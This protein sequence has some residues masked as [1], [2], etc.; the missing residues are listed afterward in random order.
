[1]T[2][3]DIHADIDALSVHLDA[4]AEAMRGFCSAI[5]KAFMPAF[6]AVL[7]A[8]RQHLLWLKRIALCRRLPRLERL[9]WRLPDWLVDKLSFD[10][11]MAWLGM[12]DGMGADK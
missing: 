10:R 6:E 8:V 7:E 2:A 11:A 5:A 4:L 12:G 9:W 1:M 3:D